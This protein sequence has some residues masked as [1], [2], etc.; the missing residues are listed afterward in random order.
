MRKK[1]NRK[2]AMCSLILCVLLC[3]CGSEGKEAITIGRELSESEA[4]ADH[5]SSDNTAEGQEAAGG[6]APHTV[7]EIRVYVCGAVVSPGVVAL[8]EGSRAEDALLAAGGFADAACR[9]HVN[10][11]ERLSDGQK[12]YFPTQ[13]EAEASAVQDAKAG[14][15]DINS[16]D[17]AALCTLP[18]IGETRAADIISYRETNGA[19]ENPEDIMNVPGIKTSVYGKI[20]DLI[21]VR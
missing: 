4:A 8:P 9:D 7:Q 11:A 6:S 16:A 20:K 2:A 10:L 21:T 5:V 14:L 12:L 19:F 1:I 18:G 13:E 15:I 17:A 3:G